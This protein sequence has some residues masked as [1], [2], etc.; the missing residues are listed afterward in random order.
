VDPS[1]YHRRSNFQKAHENLREFNGDGAI[2]MKGA[3]P[4]MSCAPPVKGASR[5]I[6]YCATF[7]FS[8]KGNT[9]VYLQGGVGEKGSM[10]DGVSYLDELLECQIDKPASVA[11]P[12]AVESYCSAPTVL[13]GAKRCICTRCMMTPIQSSQIGPAVMARGQRSSALVL[14]MFIS[15]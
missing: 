2:F 6:A 14:A 8:R 1:G 12:P 7:E 4:I 10:R 5:E 13:G 3:R 15:L 11:P 9:C